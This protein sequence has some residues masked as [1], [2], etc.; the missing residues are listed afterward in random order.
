MFISDVLYNTRNKE[1]ELD[2]PITSDE[3]HAWFHLN[4]ASPAA[5]NIEQVNITKILSTVWLDPLTLASRLQV[6]RSHHATTTRFIYWP[7]VLTERFSILYKNQTKQDA[8]F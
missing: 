2:A 7:K 5:R 4:A 6:R 1:L 8:S 3:C